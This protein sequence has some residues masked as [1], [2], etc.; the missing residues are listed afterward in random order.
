MGLDPG[1]A[2]SHSEAKA[3]VQLLSHP[4]VPKTWF[5][6]RKAEREREREREKG[7]RERESP[8]QVLA[9]SPTWGLIL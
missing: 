2:G 5:F 7:E 1:T 4:G 6:K 9:W 3:G 8:K